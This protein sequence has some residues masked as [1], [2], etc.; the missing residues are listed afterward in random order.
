[1][2]IGFLGQDEVLCQRLRQLAGVEDVRSF[3]LADLTEELSD[4]EVILISDR[5]IAAYELEQVKAKFQVSTTLLYLLSYSIH[6]GAATEAKIVADRLGITIIPPKRTPDQIAK[7]IERYTLDSFAPESGGNVIAFMGTL[8]QSGVTATVLSLAD[9]LGKMTSAKVGVISLNAFT[10]GDSFL[11]YSGSYLDDLYAQIKE[12]KLLTPG[13]LAGHMQVTPTFSYLAGNGDLLKRYRYSSDAAE[14]IIACARKQFDIVLL[15]A[16]ANPD[17]NLCLQA[18]LQADLRILVSTQQP[19]AVSMWRKMNTLLRMVGNGETMP[20]MLVLNRFRSLYGDAKR[21][22]QVMELPLLG[23]LPDL[24]E[25]GQYC[26]VEKRLL[27]TTENGR[28]TSQIR[29]IG[30]QLQSLYKWAAQNEDATKKRG[31]RLFSR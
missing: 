5:Y 7:E 11:S 13:E 14:H 10:P 30:K 31:W 15:D 16:G 8:S 28:Y 24:E 6:A 20:F 2:K 4:F 26:E 9:E 19:A 1:M 12:T 29:E 17:N 23:I 25:E 18:L 21:F 22:E 3:D 27:T